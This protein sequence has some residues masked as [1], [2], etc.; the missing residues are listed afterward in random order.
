ML[1][2]L[3]HSAYRGSSHQGNVNRH[4]T[5][6][7][8]W[9][10]L[11]LS[12]WGGWG[13]LSTV[14]YLPR[15]VSTCLRGRNRRGRGGTAPYGCDPCTTAQRSFHLYRYHPH[16]SHLS[17]FLIIGMEYI[18]Q[19]YDILNASRTSPSADQCSVVASTWL[20]SA[21]QRIS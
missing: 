7:I 11:R 19:L 12:Q 6:N 13:S 3:K 21:D 10:L 14:Q 20:E 1:V 2:Y 18:W 5:F 15:A 16:L 17:A 9:L 4:H 8:V